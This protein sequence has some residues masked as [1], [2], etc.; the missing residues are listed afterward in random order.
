[1]V[2]CVSEGQMSS[3]RSG[4]HHKIW[5]PINV[6]FARAGDELFNDVLN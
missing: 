6:L 2:L 3:E 1:M 4:F 5:F